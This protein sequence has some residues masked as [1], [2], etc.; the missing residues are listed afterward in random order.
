MWA[1]STNPVV[2]FFF[3]LLL[4][5]HQP[6]HQSGTM[7]LLK[8]KV[9]LENGLFIVRTALLF[10]ISVKSAGREQFDKTIKQIWF[11]QIKEIIFFNYKTKFSLQMTDFCLL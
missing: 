8:R 7:I 6:C 9:K 2:D 10:Q 1:W 5:D 3:L 4:F 11:L